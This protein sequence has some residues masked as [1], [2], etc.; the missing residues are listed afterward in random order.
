VSGGGD[1]V[2]DPG[3]TLTLTTIVR[4]VSIFPL[5]AA[6]G[7]LT[8]STTGASISAGSSDFPNLGPGQAGQNTTSFQATVDRSVT[9]GADLQFTLELTAGQSGSKMAFKVPTGRTD[10][11]S[12]FSDDIETGDSQWTHRSLVKKKKKQIDTWVLT[13]KRF[14][15]GANAWFTPNPDTAVDVA[16]ETKPI[17]LPTGRRNLRL[18]FYHTFQLETVFDGA[19]LEI[20]DGGDF[21][22][23]GPK[24]LKGGYTGKLLTATDNP[25][26]GR[27]A[28]T[29]GR[30]GAFQDVVV[31]LD[32]YAGKTVVVR[33]R[34]G[35]DSSVK[36]TGWYID[37]VSVSSDR[38]TCVQVE[39][40]PRLVPLRR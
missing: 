30:I 40:E 2:A 35:C 12:A 19:V 28:W 25:L 1:A 17:I 26:Q 31:D 8:S 16:L 38:V 24:I 27:D 32:S 5:N 29:G 34:F 13:T 36:A 18:I 23:L 14:R 33:F 6:R 22:D 21:V 15:S 37:D 11:Q 10:T 39:M 4:N 20:S 3:E 9:C 7:L